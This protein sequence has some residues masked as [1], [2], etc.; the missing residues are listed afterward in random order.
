MEEVEE[1]QPAGLSESSGRPTDGCGGAAL[2]DKAVR[3]SEIK[4]SAGSSWTCLYIVPRPLPSCP[5]TE[6]RTHTVWRRPS[7]HVQAP[8]YLLQSPVEGC[9]KA[10]EAGGQVRIWHHRAALAPSEFTS[11]A[12]DDRSRTGNH[13]WTHTHART[14]SEVSSAAPVCH[15]YRK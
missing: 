14:C 12:L 10:G 11:P 7:L 15:F 2:A 5:P 4:P 9:P 3:C 6:W 1:T 8:P 13:I